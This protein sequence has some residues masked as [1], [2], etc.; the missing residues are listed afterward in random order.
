VCRE[1]SRDRAFSELHR[2][3]VSASIGVEA[4]ARERAAA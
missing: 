2:S 1:W 3:L 4:Q